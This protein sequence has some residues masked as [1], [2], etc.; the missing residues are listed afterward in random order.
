MTPDGAAGQPAALQ[1]RHTTLHHGIIDGETL[2]LRLEE[3]LEDRTGHERRGWR[4]CPLGAARIAPAA[5]LGDLDLLERSKV[6]ERS[7]GNLLLH[8]LRN[9]IAR[10]EPKQQ[11][12]SVAV[13][14]SSH[15]VAPL[16]LGAHERVIH[17]GADEGAGPAH[18]ILTLGIIRVPRSRQQSQ[19]ADRRPADSISQ[20]NQPLDAVDP[21]VG[22]L[23]SRHH[24]SQRRVP[25][26]LH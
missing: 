7:P 11:L 20:W 22:P 10:L 24:S 13:P 23:A 21:F 3:G 25:R 14:P 15:V 12:E 26:L 1:R 9:S 16:V 2:A 17:S 19:R 5:N 8:P 6:L 4:R 18:R